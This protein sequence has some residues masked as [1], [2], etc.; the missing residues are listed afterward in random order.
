MAVRS[1]AQASSMTRKAAATVG[2]LR[3]DMAHALRDG[4]RR[5]AKVIIKSHFNTR[6]HE[7]IR[8]Q[9]WP[10][11]AASTRRQKRGR[12]ILKETGRMER[13]IISNPRIRFSQRN[14]KG[15]VDFR[16][17]T[18]AKYHDRGIPGR[19]P[20][21][22]WSN[23]TPQDMERIEEWTDSVL[24]KLTEKRHRAQEQS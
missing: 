12:F 1:S 5:Y 23:P 6:Q 7:V 17:V 20:R 8:D 3:D 18:Y 4:L 21:R 24:T 11:L 14:M 10:P 15:T 19:L 9:R 22:K 2:A 13:S 16:P